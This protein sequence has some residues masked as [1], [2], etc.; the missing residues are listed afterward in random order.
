MKEVLK[1]MF[2]RAWG[3]IISGNVTWD[4][5]AEEKKSVSII[6]KQYIYPLMIFCI[7]L[8]FLFD[9][10]YA[11]D[12]RIETGILS[13]I[14]T[15]LSMFGGYYI[16]N[17]LCFIYLKRYRPELASKTECETI[18]AYSYTIIILIEILISIIPSLFFLRILS[19]F[20]GYVVWEGTRAMWQL[21]EEERGNI[22]LIFSIIIIF[23]PIVISRIIHMMLPNV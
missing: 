3:I 8:A 6:R 22:V 9:T 14:V 23:I 7:I 4:K 13:V 10:L 11:S 1:N 16:S 12:R 18:V 21:K 17:I 20:V 2:K 5:I 15:S 19:M